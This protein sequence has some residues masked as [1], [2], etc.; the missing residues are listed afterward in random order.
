M[1][2]VGFNHSFKIRQ[3]SCKCEKDTP[4]IC[5]PRAPSHDFKSIRLEWRVWQRQTSQQFVYLT[6]DISI[7]IKQTVMSFDDANR[8]CRVSHYGLKNWVLPPYHPTF[9][10]LIISGTPPNLVLKSIFEATFPG[11]KSVDYQTWFTVAF[12]LSLI[13]I[14]A[15]WTFLC[16]VYA[17]SSYWNLITGKFIWDKSG[18]TILLSI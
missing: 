4:T 15:G 2:R 16:L 1:K 8:N 14:I 10:I 6:D 12:P 17:R 11:Q 7:L 13:L 18:K 5:T 9:V 3:H